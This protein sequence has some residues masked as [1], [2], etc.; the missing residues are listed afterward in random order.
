[1]RSSYGDPCERPPENGTTAARGNPA[2]QRRDRRRVAVTPS[3]PASVV[4]AGLTSPLWPDQRRRPLPWPSWPPVAGVGV[5]VGVGVD[6]ISSAA[7]AGPVADRPL[8]MLGDKA[9]DEL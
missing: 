9:P 2:T 1:M 6:L 3:P 5:G 4:L 7:A 8:P